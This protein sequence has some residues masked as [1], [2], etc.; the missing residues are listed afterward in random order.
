[1]ELE[2]VLWP[3]LKG[4]DAEDSPCEG[5]S[6]RKEDM[7]EIGRESGPKARKFCKKY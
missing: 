6:E 4:D 3:A 5:A 7:A 2:P 1:M